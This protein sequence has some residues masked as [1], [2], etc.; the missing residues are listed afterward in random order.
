MK[1]R[2]IRPSFIEESTLFSFPLLTEMFHFSR[3]PPFQL[4]LGGNMTSSCWVSP[5]GYLRVKGC[6]PPHRS[7]SQVATSF[8]GS[9]RPRHPP[10]TLIS[11]TT[12][13]RGAPAVSTSIAIQF[14]T[15]V[16]YPILILFLTF[17]RFI[18]L[19][20]FRPSVVF[21]VPARRHAA[22]SDQGLR[23]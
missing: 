19:S 23:P 6:L 20:R 8:I 7:F 13:A 5:F 3:C 9:R 11:T 22:G 21:P 2:S 14:S 4:S 12:E 10:S 18:Q 17:S 16:L 15:N 1:E